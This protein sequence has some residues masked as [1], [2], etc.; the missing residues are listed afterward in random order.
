[1]RGRCRPSTQNECQA[2]GVLYTLRNFAVGLLRVCYQRTFSKSFLRFL[3][4]EPYFSAMPVDEYRLIVVLPRSNGCKQTSHWL[5]SLF[6]S[7]HFPRR[8]CLRCLAP[9]RYLLHFRTAVGLGGNPESNHVYWAAEGGAIH[10]WKGAP[11]LSNVSRSR[12]GEVVAERSIE[13]VELAPLFHGLSSDASLP[14]G[15]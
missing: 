7:T 14:W 2:R 5:P 3:K 11:S 1:V 10:L 12:Q 8:L 15:M 6:F 4:H 9:P 13:E